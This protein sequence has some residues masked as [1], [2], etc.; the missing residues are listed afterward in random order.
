[1]GIAMRKCTGAAQND[2]EMR[3]GDQQEWDPRRHR[4]NHR[5]HRHP[6]IGVRMTTRREPVGEPSTRDD[7]QRAGQGD[8]N[9]NTFPGF[10]RRPVMVPDEKSCDPSPAVP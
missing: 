2:G 3:I 8:D 9:A 1:M 6:E 7:T 10:R 4:C 5:Q